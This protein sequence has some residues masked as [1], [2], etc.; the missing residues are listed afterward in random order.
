MSSPNVAVIGATGAVGQVAL[1]ILEERAFPMNSLRLCASPSSVGKKITFRGVEIEVET[2]TESLFKDTDIAFIAAGSSLSKIYAPL[3]AS[4]DCIAIDKSSA[5]RMDPKV[6]LVVPEI[7]ANDIWAHEG[8]IS[9][10]NCSTTQM[11]MAL[12]PLHDVNPI[13]RVVVDTYQSVSG[14]GK[15]AMEELQVQSSQI[16]EGLPIKPEAYPHQIAF[17][18]LP[19]VET[20]LDD[21]YTTEERKMR[22][23]TRKILHSD[24]INIS[25]TCV[26]IPVPI[27]HSEAL[28][29]EFEKPMSPSEARSLLSSFSGVTVLDD[30]F[31]SKYPL[32]S[33]AT[34]RDDVFVGRIRADD[35][36]PNGLVMWVVSDNLRKGAATNGI[37][38]AEE[39]I[40]KDNSA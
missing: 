12:S 11:V 33:S 28:H 36:H 6:P 8:I 7:N 32:A 40:N 34:G 31:D 14:T 4:L 19:Q 5:F 24:S 35:S 27:S 23:E 18:A 26:R 13:R 17:N 20:F 9:V 38:I 21:G 1:Q 22:D 10:P 15:A 2:P 37:Q 16:L 25:A 39:I 30:P 3:A 29:I